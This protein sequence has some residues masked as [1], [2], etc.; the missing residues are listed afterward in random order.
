L[1]GAFIAQSD[2]SDL[3]RKFSRTKK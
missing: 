2:F 3:T 1:I